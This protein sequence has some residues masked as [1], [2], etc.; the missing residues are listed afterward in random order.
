VHI[1]FSSSNSPYAASSHF[2]VLT[3]PFCR[4]LSNHPPTLII[5]AQQVQFTDFKGAFQI[6]HDLF[7]IFVIDNSE[8][9]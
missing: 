9:S 2:Y 3:A 6:R 4:Q 5:I 7:P 1:L 8:N